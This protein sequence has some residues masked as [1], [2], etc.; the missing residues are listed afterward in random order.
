M[1]GFLRGTLLAALS[2]IALALVGCGGG[3]DNSPGAS[4]PTAVASRRQ[5]C[6]R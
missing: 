6:G 4:A 1:N 3:G 5:Q 2:G